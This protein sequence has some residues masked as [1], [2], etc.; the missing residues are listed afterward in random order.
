MRCTS[1]EI[2]SGLLEETVIA[3]RVKHDLDDFFPSKCRKTGRKPS[4]SF[5]SG[6]V[7]KLEIADLG[8]LRSRIICN[9]RSS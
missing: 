9:T 8:A 6:N 7:V 4:Y 2:V 3:C 5:D 1:N